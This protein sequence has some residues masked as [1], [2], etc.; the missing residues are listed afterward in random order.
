M[1][2]TS[3][4]ISKECNTEKYLY[5]CRFMPEGIYL[6]AREL[7]PKRLAQQINELIEDKELYYEYF[8][9]RGYYSFFNPASLT[10]E[11]EYCKF[12]EVL[13]DEKKMARSVTY[14][15]LAEWWNRPPSYRPQ[16][17]SPNYTEPQIYS[18]R[19]F[20][21]SRVTKN[22]DYGIVVV[23]DDD[24]P[25]SPLL[26]LE[27]EPSLARVYTKTKSK[28]N[29]KK[30]TR[31]RKS[32]KKMKS[33]AT[34]QTKNSESYSD[35]SERHEHSHNIHEHDG[36]EHEEHTTLNFK[37]GDRI[38]EWHEDLP[39]PTRSNSQQNV[40]NSKVAEERHLNFFFDAPTMVTQVYR[41]TTPHYVTTK[42]FI[43]SVVTCFMT[44]RTVPNK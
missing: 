7:S 8:R 9:W 41:T 44:Q 31:R 24:Y 11:S 42:G 39:E 6:N 36:H 37:I 18:R 19:Y 3:N 23:T 21:N 29:S 32:K 33:N 28:S 27:T 17:H 34:D 38:L 15:N 5:S 40:A 22:D 25:E 13:N 14:L 1:F 16:V 4:I 2:E 12:C 10:G 30:K 20:K 35:D 26:E 43:V